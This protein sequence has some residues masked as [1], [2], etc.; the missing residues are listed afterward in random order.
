MADGASFLQRL[1]FKYVRPALGR[2]TFKTVLTLGEQGGTA[3]GKYA[4]LVR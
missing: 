3:A 1:V 2:V 4:P